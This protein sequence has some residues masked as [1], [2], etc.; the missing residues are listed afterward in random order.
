MNR[1][2]RNNIEGFISYLYKKKYNK[3]PSYDIVQSWKILSNEEIQHHLKELYTS[4]GEPSLKINEDLNS[5][6][7]NFKDLGKNKFNKNWLYIFVFIWLL[8]LFLTAYFLFT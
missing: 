3:N 8:I 5:Y 2:D 4:W 1:I 6:F 7:N